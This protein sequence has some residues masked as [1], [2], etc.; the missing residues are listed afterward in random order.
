M[1]SDAKP[2]GR[3]EA[4]PSV[5]FTCSVGGVSESIV[6]ILKVVALVQGLALCARISRVLAR[7]QTKHTDCPCK[8]V[9]SHKD[10]PK[11]C[12]LFHTFSHRCT[13]NWLI[14]DIMT[15]FGGKV[16]RQRVRW[17]ESEAGESAQDAGRAPECGRLHSKGGHSDVKGTVAGQK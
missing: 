15:P 4:F 14:P 5:G 7:T 3:R 17:R 16:A 1:T 6:D 9:T 11:E 13:L 12:D 2:L 10:T 8:F